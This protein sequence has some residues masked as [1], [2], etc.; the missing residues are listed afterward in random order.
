LSLT[1]ILAEKTVFVQALNNKK[2][3]KQRMRSYNNLPQVV[4][5]DRRTL[6][7]TLAVS[8]I[9]HLMLFVV[10]IFAPGYAKERNPSLSFIN[11]SLV[12]FPT[13]GKASLPD[14]Q[15]PAKIEKQLTAKKKAPEVKISPKKNSETDKKPSNAISI[16]PKKKKIK[17]S[18]KKKTFKSS[19]VVKS[20][21]TKIEKKVEESRP[22]EI[23]KAIARIEDRVKKTETTD[24]K[25]YQD[26][27]GSEIPG[28]SGAGSKKILELIDIYQIE[29]AYQIQKNWAFS[30]QLARGGKDL[31]AL[32][33]IKIMPNGEIKDIW[34]DK[35]SGNRYL[36]ET[37]EKAIRK[38]NPLPPLP[39]G[40]LR[41]FFEAGF[42]FTPEGIM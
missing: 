30:E 27:K 28:Q 4:E 23:K 14:K 35:R 8:F 38:S 13:Q 20:A 16:A 12:T 32:I 15:Q 29:I 2:L 17:K 33:A 11:V 37:V 21:I 6:F 19:K 24:H 7:S 25:K 3:M 10:L 1:Q 39:K 26:V 18:L 36:D 9:C 34:F 40:Y 42:R 31:E 41:P 22:D 5:N